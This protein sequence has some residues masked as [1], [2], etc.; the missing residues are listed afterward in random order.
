MGLLKLILRTVNKYLKDL[1]KCCKSLVTV[2][3]KKRNINCKLTYPK[4]IEY[5]RRVKPFATSKLSENVH[6]RKNVKSSIKKKLI[7]NLFLKETYELII[8]L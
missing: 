8:F 7:S 5:R 6:K 2:M 3:Q 4:S 1:E